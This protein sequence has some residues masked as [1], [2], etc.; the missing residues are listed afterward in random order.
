M[1]RRQPWHDRYKPVIT[2]ETRDMT[3]TVGGIRQAMQ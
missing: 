2:I 1:R 3:L